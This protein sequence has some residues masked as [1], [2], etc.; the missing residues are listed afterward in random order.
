MRKQ[1]ALKIQQLYKCM[2]EPIHAID[3]Y[4]RDDKH[5]V[6][7][8]IQMVLKILNDTEDCNLTVNIDTYKTLTDVILYTMSFKKDIK[9]GFA[10][11][12][13][14]DMDFFNRLFCKKYE[15]MKPLFKPIMNCKTR[16]RLEFANGSVLLFGVTP[17]HFCGRSFDILVID[18]G[19]V[20]DVVFKDGFIPLAPD[21]RLIRIVEVDHE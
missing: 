1:T 8:E 14:V 11:K 10:S 13:Y 3:N 21:G 18:I 7:K 12:S 15:N 9:I 5:M 2:K 4:I 17:T 16:D 19:V 6:Q 20:D